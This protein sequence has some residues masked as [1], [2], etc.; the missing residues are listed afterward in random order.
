MT[1]V[2]LKPARVRVHHFFVGMG[3]C[4]RSEDDTGAQD[5]RS[6]R[7]RPGG[8]LERALT[9]AAIGV[10]AATVFMAIDRTSPGAALD[11]TFGP[12]SHEAGAIGTAGGERS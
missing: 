5:H 6:R 1:R 8:G 2:P 12:N 4:A 11:G 10:L 9:I 3:F 7:V